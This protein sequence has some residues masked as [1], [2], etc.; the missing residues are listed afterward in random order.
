MTLVRTPSADLLLLVIGFIVWSIAFI[1]LYAVNAI[2]C[3]FG[4]N[5]R[6]QRTVLVGLFVVHALFLAWFARQNYRY[7]L[8]ADAE[9]R[10]MI[11]YTGFG[12]TVAALGSMI[13]V[14]APSLFITMCI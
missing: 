12:L 2:G 9:P 3:E 7:L 1:A 6:F 13:F 14:L 5:Q 8:A 10:K 11:A 4:W